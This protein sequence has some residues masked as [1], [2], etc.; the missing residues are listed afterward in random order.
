MNKT[1]W[2][3][4]Y[5]LEKVMKKCE[6]IFDIIH[7]GDPVEYELLMV[8]DE[9]RNNRLYVKIGKDNCKYLVYGYDYGKYAIPWDYDGDVIIDE[10]CNR[11]FE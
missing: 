8:C 3:D 6:E 10:E 1:E 11:L 5:M 2:L 9:I 4:N 7:G